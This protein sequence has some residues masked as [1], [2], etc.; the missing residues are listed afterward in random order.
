[1]D[2]S[3]HTEDDSLLKL[4]IDGVS[5]TVNNQKQVSSTL[6]DLICRIQQ[7][8]N[9]TRDT[10]ETLAQ[11][12]DSLEQLI[13]CSTLAVRS[14]AMLHRTLTTNDRVFAWAFSLFI[15]VSVGF[16]INAFEPVNSAMMKFF[17]G[18][19]IGLVFG[20]VA[21]V[22]LPILQRRLYALRYVRNAARAATERR[23]LSE[24]D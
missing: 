24:L 22:G 9:R 7:L 1:V 13:E 16:F 5:A 15:C 19:G 10:R 21:I 3:R 2:E 23:E 12:Q 4:L 8:D 18:A 14:D 6:R 20:L 11:N 17:A